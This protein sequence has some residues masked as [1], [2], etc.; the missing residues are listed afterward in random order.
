V[1]D[2]TLIVYLS[3]HGA[4]FPGAKTTVYEPGLR[5][6]LIVRHPRARG[7]A[8]SPTRWSAG[9]ISRPRCSSTPARRRRPTGSTSAAPR[10][11]AAGTCPRSTGCTG[12]RSS[13]SRA[14]RRAGMGRGVRVAHLPR[15]PDV[16][17]DAG[18]ARPPY[19]LIWNIAY[20]LPFPFATDLWTSATWQSAVAEQGRTRLRPPH[21]RELRQPAGVRAVRP[22]ARPARVAQPRGRP[23]PRGPRAVGVQGPKLREFQSR[24]SD[25]WILKWS[26]Q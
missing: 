16:L 24:T 2:R 11:A 26:Y 3:D 18:G 6:P 9:S 20:Q 23:G 15:D 4:A 1:Y 5:S 7:G 17:P 25:P 14:A 10:C 22:G 12:D 19:K 21:G 8:S 13:R